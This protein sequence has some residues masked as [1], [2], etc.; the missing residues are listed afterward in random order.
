MENQQESPKPHAL[1]MEEA[2]LGALMLEQD[3]LTNVID[4]LK[5]EYFYKPEHRLIFDAIR[6]L[7]YD[8]HPVDILTVVNKIK[9]LGNL[10][11]IGGAYYISQLTNHA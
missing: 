5:T 3:A 2:I 4:V 8:E 10:E 1:D 11:K 9:E 6:Q 7:Y